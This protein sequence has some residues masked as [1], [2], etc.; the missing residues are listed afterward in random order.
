MDFRAL[1]QR[2][3]HFPSGKVIGRPG[4]RLDGLRPRALPRRRDPVHGAGRA[5]LPGDARAQ[6]ALLPPRAEEGP[7]PPIFSLSL[8]ENT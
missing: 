6:P 5:R 8:D 1:S 7:L 4:L 3:K 2:K